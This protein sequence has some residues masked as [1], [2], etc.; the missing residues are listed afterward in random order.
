MHAKLKDAGWLGI[1]TEKTEK[2]VI[3]IK[4]VVPES[5]AVA[6]GF[7]AG[8]VLV[9]I[10]G[11]EI[12][13]ANKE[14]LKAAKK[15]LVAGGEARYTVLRQG[16]KKNLTAHLVAPPRAVLAQWIGEHMLSEHVGTQ[17]AAK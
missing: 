12:S 2:G 6:A 13:E 7:Q 5:P 3:T 10:N 8:D 1:E 9:A 11:V 4:A 15:S 14:A 16:A 17:L